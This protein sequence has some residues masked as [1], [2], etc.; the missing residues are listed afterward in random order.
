MRTLEELFVR[1]FKDSIHLLGNKDIYSVKLPPVCNSWEVSGSDEYKVMGINLPNYDKLNGKIVRR[2]PSGYKVQR[3]VIDKARRSYKR[4]E[5]GSFVYQDYKAPSGTIMVYSPVDIELP[6]KRYIKNDESCGYVDF[7]SK[8]G[9]TYFIYALPREVL[10]KINQTALV[11]S[12]KNMNNYQ[13][14]GY[15]ILNNGV[16]Y[17]HIIPYSP[18]SKYTGS[19]VLKTGRSTDYSAEIHLISDYWESIGLIPN[20][21]LSSLQSG[22]NLCLKPTIVGYETYNPIEPNPISEKE[23][24]GS[25]EVTAGEPSKGVTKS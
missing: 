2:V 5:D 3:R 8:N 20:I 9:K 16:I 14:M 23:I 25:E 11:I 10:Y 17:I 15:N 19:R 6:Y 12:V 21:A 24:F 7:M 1:E 22:E 4:N 18:T 13:G